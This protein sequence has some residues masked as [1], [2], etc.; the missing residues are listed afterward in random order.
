MFLALLAVDSRAATTLIDYGS[1]WKYFKGVSEAST[2][3]TTAWRAIGYGDSGWLSGA[4]PIYYGE[5]TGGTGTVLN[6]M[7]GLYSSVYFRQTFTIA[8]KTQVAALQ[9][10]IDY[11]DGYIVWI[12]GT[13]VD[14]VFAPASPTYNALAT[15]SHESTYGGGTLDT[16]NLAN[17]Q[18]FLVNG[19]NV[20]AVQAFNMSLAGSTDFVMRLRLTALEPCPNDNFAS[21]IALASALP[22]ST[23]GNSNAATAESGE[24]AH[25][26]QAA[27]SS[28]WWSWT[29][30]AD[31]DVLVSTVGS[32]FDTRLAIYTGTALNN[33][34][35]VAS[36]DDVGNSV[37]TSILHFAA[38]NGTTYWIAV[39]GFNGAQGTVS[40]SLSVLP[41]ISIA[42][43]D[44][45]ATEAAGNT[46]TF[47]LTRTGSTASPL[48]VYFDTSGTA[49]D[50]VDYTTLGDSV[51]FGAGQATATLT[52]TPIQDALYEGDETVIV[53]LK[54]A[55]GYEVSG[56]SYSATVTII[57]DEPSVTGT[58]EAPAFSP[59]RGIYGGPVTVTLTCAT[60][61]STIRYTTDGSA[62]S[63]TAGTI[64]TNPI[65]LS[66]TT[67]LRAVAYKSG[68]KPS[69]VQTHTY[70]NIP[71][72]AHQADI[73]TGNGPTGWPNAG[74]PNGSGFSINYGMDTTVVN[75]AP[76]SGTIQNDLKSLPSFSIAMSLNDLFN[77]STGI[78]S[79]PDQDGHAWERPCSVELLDPAEGGL[80]QIN[81]GI[82]IRGGYSRST[83][84]PKHGLRLFFRGE[85]GGNLNY[86]MFGAFPA[87]AT[88]DCFDLRT[89]QNYSWSFAGDSQG[90]FMRDMFSRDTQRD[91]GQ[92]C[93]HGDYYHLYI[94]GQY[95]GL[96]NT[97][98]RAEAS[99]ASQYLGGNKEDYDVIKVEAGSYNINATDGNMDAWTRLWKACKAGLATNDA[100]YR[101]QGKNP[102]G[103]TNNS[104]ENLI[105]VDNLID[106]MLV[107]YYGGNLDAPISNFLSNQSPNNFYAI[108]S[109][110]ANRGFIFTSHDAEHTLLNVNQ[111]RTGPFTAG[112]TLNKSNP[113]WVFQQCWA[114][115]EFRVRVADHVQ[116][117]FFD[118]GALTPAACQARFNARKN[119]INA[120]VVAESARWGDSKR[121]PAY[122]RDGTWLPQCNSILNTYMPARS[123]IVLNQL[124]AK[125]LYATITAPT[126]DSTGGDIT[127]GFALT[128]TNPNATGRLYYT[129]DGS[130]P[131]AIGG[132][133]GGLDGGTTSI[134]ITLSATCTVKARVLDG[135]TWSALR[136]ASFYCPQD[137]SALRITEIMYNPPDWL[138]PDLT[139]VPGK[140]LEFLELKNTGTTTLNL[141]GVQ[142]TEG[143]SLV[144]PAETSLPAGA[145]LVLASNVGIFQEKYPG[146]PV[147]GQYSLHLDNGGTRITLAYPNGATILSVKYDDAPPWP[148]AADGLGF[149]LVSVNPNTNPNPDD[150]RNWRASTNAGGSPGEDDPAYSVQPVLINEALTNSVLPAVD[151]IE[152]YNPN[153]DPVNISGW[154]LTDDR[155]TPKKYRI[156]DGTSIAGHDFLQFNESQ[157]NSTPGVPPSFSLSSNGETL[158]IFSAD[159][160]G[161]LTGYSHGF[162]FG[163]AA[164]G[165]TFGRYTISTGEEHFPAAS[166]NTL[167]GV[168]A[169]PRV[170]PV[171]ISEIMYNP[172]TGY[173]QFIE[174]KNIS[175]STVNLYDTDNP[176]NTWTLNGISYSF[177][178]GTQL[179]AG[180]IIV[181]CA[182]DPATFSANHSVPAAAQ[183]FG[184]FAG[185]LQPDGELIELQRPGVPEP[186]GLGGFTVPYITVDAV[187]YNDK[188]PWPLE[189][190]GNGPSLTRWHLDQYGN[191]PIN[192]FPSS[193]AGGS[194][195]ADELLTPMAPS[196]LAATAQSSY[197]I[198]LTWTDNASNEDGFTVQRSPDGTTNWTQVGGVGPNVTAWQDTFVSPTTT[199]YY[200]VC[201]YTGIQP[202]GWTLVASATTPQIPAPDAPS[203]FS[204]VADSETAIT[205]SW[206]DNAADE[207]NYQIDWSPDGTTNWYKLVV[208]P[209][210]TTSYQDTALAPVTTYYYRV[211]A[212]NAGG[213]SDAE[214]ANATTPPPPP[215]AD[216]TA[217][218][219]T[220]YS[221]TEI[222]LAW[223][224]NATN[225]VGFHI[226]R[227][228]DGT[229]GWMQIAALP[230]N[231]SSWRD[232]GRQPVTSYSY[233]VIAYHDYS[234]SSPSNTATATT[235][236]VPVPTAP[237]GLTAQGNSPTGALLGWVDNSGNE[238]SFTI[239]RSNNGAGDWAQVGSAAAN[240]TDWQDNNLQPSRTYYYR[241]FALNQGGPSTASNTAN[242]TTLDAPLP[243]APRTLTATAQSTTTVK[244]TWTDA[245]DNETGFRV[246]SSPNGNNGWTVKTTLDPDSTTWTD[247]GLTPGTGVYYRVYS[248]NDWGASASNTASVTLP[249]PPPPATPTGL[250]AAVL[251]WTRVHLTWNDV[252][253][254]ETGYAVE[255]SADGTGTWQELVRLPADSKS[256]TDGSATPAT[257]RYYRVRAFHAYGNSGYSNIASATTP[258]QSLTALQMT[259]IMY[260]P[261]DMGATIGDDL[262]FLEL[263]NT[264]ADKLFLD[265]VNFTSGITYTFPAGTTL[266]P[267]QFCVLVTNPAA[268]SAKY[269]SI[270]PS[271]T[272]TGHLAD[273]GEKIAM[274]DASGVVFLSFTYNDAS[275]WPAAADGHGFSLVP[276]GTGTDPDKA[277]YWRASA[278]IGGSP[279]ADDPAA[280]AFAEVKVNELLTHT[281]LPEEDTFEIYNPSSSPADVSY[282]YL[283]DD[284]SVPK[285]YALPPNT[286]IPAGGY[287]VVGQHQFGFILNEYGEDGYIFSAD[288]AGNLTGYSHGT[289]FE[290]GE[291]NISFGRYIISTGEEHFP[292]QIKNTLGGPNAGPRVGPVVINEMMYFPAAGSDE[293]VELRNIT[294]ASVKL[295]DPDH[296]ANTWRLSGTGFVFPEMISISA[297]ALAI[298][299][300]LDPAAFR[301]KYAIPDDVQVFG[302]YSGNLQDNGELIELQKPGKQDVDPV[303][304]QIIV[305]YITVDAVR[306]N[307][308]APWP[309]AAAGGGYSLERIAAD[310]YGNDP[311][312]WR[313]SAAVGGSP[314]RL[315]NGY[316]AAPSNLAATGGQGLVSLAWTD[317]S[318]NESGFKLERS[319][320]GKAGWI[321]LGNAAADATTWTDTSVVAATTYYYRVSAVNSSGASAYS[322][323]ASATTFSG[324]GGP[325]NP[326]VDS[327][328]DG[329]SDQDE[330]AAGTNPH[331]PNSKPGGTADFDNDGIPDDQDADADNDGVSNAQ[332]AAD[333]TDPYD[334]ASRNVIAMQVAKARISA[335]YDVSGK[336]AASLSGSIPDLPKLWNPYGKTVVVLVGAAKAQ[337]TLNAK[338]MGKGTLG[339]ITI[340]LKFK[341]NPLTKKSEF[342][343]GT[344]PFMVRVR[345]TKWSET[346]VSDGLFDK[347]E[348][349][350]KGSKALPVE[351]QMDG[352]VYG[353]SVSGQYS[354]KSLKTM[355]FWK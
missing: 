247:T 92:P 351:L 66:A 145:F 343:G 44:A 282:W 48:L 321:L 85:Y 298:I 8:D 237:S 270:T 124:I 259:E 187:R 286:V 46:G 230:A 117:H 347:Q 51:T 105:D 151:E 269:P 178:T 184:P 76:Y 320:D 153:A 65:D 337:F 29:A 21:A 333:G 89:F 52:V 91:M 226:E 169:L 181:V 18:S 1:T 7:R 330:L 56:T 243:A 336:D 211:Y 256:Y 191:D 238:T 257:K 77:S 278:A 273:G 163:A 253:T 162:E 197:Q 102:D 200:R 284:R 325:A 135:S 2:P 122:T 251:G 167:G 61:G 123:N 45:T 134:A 204:A 157:F 353:T 305:P 317:N 146:V 331:D 26:G 177:P 172:A 202:S 115:A 84:N 57:D 81:A 221:D 328:G 147:F 53:T 17:P 175:S 276:A 334:P 299:S 131:R 49:D 101:I 219:A 161:N 133:I 302:P 307:D 111:D 182:I 5:N 346:W 288:A 125:G 324:G 266:G 263:K 28:V 79:H 342:Q 227:S 240:A 87:P 201:A 154:Y 19:T 137:F 33:L 97:E 24:P 264:A 271:G 55:A 209:A 12:N 214:M 242:A 322:N 140:D 248:V 205:L 23:L 194:P 96:Y 208:L 74:D 27:A 265:G 352:K 254:D 69:D 215:P 171:V 218:S 338:G 233:R 186:D 80:F 262:E 344:V 106:Y 99:F 152:L 120:A 246:E 239:E 272:Y 158:Y 130:D 150:A 165:V 252:A 86:R 268:F 20:I 203:G 14:S 304:K 245:A 224:D 185:V 93:T 40:L 118:G 217:L 11:D 70:V 173:D 156:A 345:N 54:A 216:P 314:G 139:L 100:Y 255:R 16:K 176:A 311:I 143:I 290:A 309:T 138:K 281:E 332:E 207:T 231:S 68:L 174:L 308:K 280:P 90:V 37:L 349:M 225:E 160:A 22:L 326:P 196:N 323:V 315:D 6:D 13:Q 41:V 114:N 289:R 275:P 112:D 109:R 155:K 210:D 229:S 341:R 50:Y 277:S 82:R 166:A 319:A 291:T 244:L 327:D 261:P 129:I 104:Y 141:S 316:P 36:N 313:A 128:I 119:Q 241:V 43:T 42:A 303:T 274:A 350:L 258:P 170:G 132:G 179:E 206:T 220:A 329:I 340:K 193:A 234:A 110:V 62:P 292:S 15:G 103:T 59:P 199:Y 260:S 212:F 354:S 78:W 47:T 294:S 306:Y 310:Q 30:A 232:S 188:A 300:P 335:R 348:N 198:N 39:D 127:P 10:D 73:H 287:L 180:G 213:N 183:V 235:M 83:G 301:A 148:A 168:N 249:L 279:G 164:P 223:T 189:P 35:P 71:E 318:N 236:N 116:R 75:V 297:G 222:D 293:F 25:A 195:G 355:K 339:T 95:W 144:F 4:A 34:V 67:P 190:D 267:G 64:Y 283:T 98:E 149:S 121:E 58:V 9:L 31:N 126:F 136:E 192:W 312:N 72:A 107:I 142:F 32:T 88:F 296:P 38:Q 228:P 60:I 94:N 3:D 113:Q 108:R 295:Y 250:T 285:K 159:L 63:E